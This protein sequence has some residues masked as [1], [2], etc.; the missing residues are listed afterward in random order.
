MNLKKIS[1][2]HQ[3]KNPITINITISMTIKLS[4]YSNL[5]K[6]AYP[7]YMKTKTQEWWIESILRHHK[8]LKFDGLWIVN[9]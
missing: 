7:D 5:G 9:F 1:A 2:G 8:T 4:I 3:V 6:V